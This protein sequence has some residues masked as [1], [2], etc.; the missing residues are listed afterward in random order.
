MQI[1]LGSIVILK[2]GGP[3]MTVNELIVL[4]SG[5]MARCLFFDDNLVLC[6]H[7]FPV[8]AIRVLGND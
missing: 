6:E 4:E 1:T 7:R 8:Y 2:S 5:A 3:R